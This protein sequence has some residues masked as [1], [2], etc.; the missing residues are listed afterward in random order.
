MFLGAAENWKDGREVVAGTAYGQEPMIS[1]VGGISQQQSY[2]M[3]AWNS[4]I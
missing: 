2:G 3:G 4:Y 1:I